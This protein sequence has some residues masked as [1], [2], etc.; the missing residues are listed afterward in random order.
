MTGDSAGSDP[1][2]FPAS[3]PFS[4]ITG[5]VLDLVTLAIALAVIVKF[6]PIGVF[7]AGTPMLKITA[8]ALVFLIILG[9][10]IVRNAVVYKKW[11]LFPPGGQEE[12][13]ALEIPRAPDP[14]SLQEH[15]GRI[16]G[17]A[18][19]IFLYL[20][21]ISALLGIQYR[22]LAP[23]LTYN[24]FF[25]I[26]IGELTGFVLFYLLWIRCLE[27]K[28]GLIPGSAGFIS[29]LGEGGTKYIRLLISWNALC[30]LWM[31]VNLYFLYSGAPL[32]DSNTY[33]VGL[34]VMVSGNVFIGLFLVLSQYGNDS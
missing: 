9:A 3:Q 28:W 15:I 32:I 23:P 21:V 4:A 5:M 17:I 26:L 7:V 16:A 29:A 13:P 1:K 12:T 8:A 24:I 2:K 27:G 30:F 22:A 19:M 18:A 14:V 25:W 33:G 20:L 31:I 34:G 11:C 6:I 10:V